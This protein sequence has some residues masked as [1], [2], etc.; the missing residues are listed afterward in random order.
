VPLV[1]GSS[2]R[3]VNL[4]YAAS[5]P[6]LASVHRAV[7]DAIAHYASIHRGQSYLSRLST[8]PTSAPATAS[9]RR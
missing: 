9:P 1:D 3:F 2:A 7:T 4:D 6:P 5:T 8:R